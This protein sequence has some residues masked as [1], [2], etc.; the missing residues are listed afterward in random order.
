MRMK[1][2]NGWVCLWVLTGMLCCAAGVRA[3]EDST[4]VR[5]DSVRTSFSGQTQ[6]VPSYGGTSAAD[7]LPAVPLRDARNRL[8][9]FRPNPADTP[10]Y[11]VNPSPLFRG[12]FSTGGTL[13]VWRGNV[14]TGRGS[15]TSIPGIGRLNEAAV[16]Y[17]RRLNDR[18]AFQA[19]INAMKLNMSYFSARSFGLST[20]LTYRAADHLW[21]T[22]Y[23]S[24]AMGRFPGMKHYQYG[25]TVGFDL[26]ER[27]SLELG[28]ER[29][30]NSMTGRWETRP[31]VIP[32]YNF[33]DKFKLGFDVGP[34]IYEIIRGIVTDKKDHG[35]GPLIRPEVPGYAGQAFRR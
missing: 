29:Y 12:D 14:F 18:L 15:Q 2:K 13:G 27:F 32:T 21:F 33:N 5:R 22:A 7:A 9:Q 1:V 10:P 35:G 26:G 11:Y 25:G 30:Y 16:G 17:A 28:V 31:V 8:P 20:A 3:Q 19:S 34:L 4:R 23:G 24:A 6:P